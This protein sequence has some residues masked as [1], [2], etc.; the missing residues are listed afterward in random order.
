MRIAVI[1]DGSIVN[2]YYRA[3]LPMRELERR[4][5]RVLW[6]VNPSFAS[7][8]DQVPDCDVVH[9]H[10]M[11]AEKDLE[12][13]RR[14][15]DAGVPVV[16]DNDDDMMALQKRRLYR[17]LDPSHRHPK[18]RERQRNWERTVEIARAA[19]VMTTPSAQLAQRYR[20]AGVE[21]VRVVENHVADADV[22]RPRTRHQGLVIGCVA[23]F[24][25]ATDLVDLKIPQVLHRLLE[26]HPGV[27][28][29]AVGHDLGI[30]H[31]R[32]ERHRVVPVEELVRF[33]TQLDV[34]IAPPVETE[35]NRSRSNI[36]LKEYAAAGAMWLASPV[37]PYVGMGE[38]QGG[39][40]VRDDEW[41][42]VLDVLAQ[43]FRRR[44]ALM[45]RAHAWGRTQGIRDAGAE[46]ERVLRSVR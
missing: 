6:P 43:D 12:A 21:D 42:D 41:F 24:E 36:K 33:E 22:R 10:R 35:F 19:S 4:G 1:Y 44:A 27:R 14:L 7:T 30:E 23:A 34:G 8:L 13:I 20:D 9:I 17:K 15:R 37:G 28:V 45:E 18:R 5:H 26:T 32:Y 46:W 39:L 16:W 40:L 25:H 29:I 2:A 38:G 3:V 11:P 31:P